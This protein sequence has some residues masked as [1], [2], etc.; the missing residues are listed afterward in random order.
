MTPDKSARSRQNFHLEKQADHSIRFPFAALRHFN[1]WT[2]HGLGVC[3]RIAIWREL[4][5]VRATKV[6]E[7]QS[8]EASTKR[9]IGLFDSS[10]FR[11]IT[12]T[13][14]VRSPSAYQAQRRCLIFLPEPILTWTT[15]IFFVK[16][17]YVTHTAS[18]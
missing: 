10:C 8:T 18:H 15:H 3:Y 9:L 13:L 5:R 7:A 17:G 2:G 6:L 14:A 12:S 16:S 1:A 11:S 4:L